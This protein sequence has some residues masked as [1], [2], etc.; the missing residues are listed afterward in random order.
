MVTQA[1]FAGG[2]GTIVLGAELSLSQLLVQ[3]FNAVV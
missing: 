1:L 2:P 3:M